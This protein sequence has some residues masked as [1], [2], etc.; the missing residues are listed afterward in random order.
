[1]SIFREGFKPE[2]AAQLK[3]RESAM[4]NR[5]TENIQYI[6]SRNAWVRMASSVNVNGTSDLAKAYVLQGGT[7]NN[8][9]LKNWTFK[10]GIGET[11]KEAYSTKTPYGTDH[12]LGIRPMPG[13]TGIDVKSKSAYGSLREVTV[14]FQCW[15]IRQLEELEL[16]YMRPGYTALVEWGW[17]PYLDN[18]KGYTATFNDFY[19][20]TLL[21]TT[22]PTNRSSIF[23]DLYKQSVSQSGNYD[24]MFGYVKNYNWSARPDGGYDCQT[25]IISTGEI[26]ESLKV[27]YVLPNLKDYGIYDTNGKGF[28]N[29]IITDG[30]ITTDK[31]RPAYEKNTLA[32]IWTELYWKWSSSSGA[33]VSGQKAILDIVRLPFPGTINA[34][35]SMIAPGSQ[36][37]VYIDLESVFNILNEYIIAK[38]SKEELI[39]L[40]TRTNTY[41]SNGNELTCVAHPLQISTDPLVC[42]IK[43]TTWEN[44]ILKTVVS[45]TQAAAAAATATATTIAEDIIKGFIDIYTDGQTAVDA[46]GRI[47]SPAEYKAVD[48]YFKN[49]TNP[50]YKYTNGGLQQAF[51]DNWITKAPSL[52]NLNQTIGNTTYVVE[53]EIT[54]IYYLYKIN[55]AFKNGSSGTTATFQIVDTSNSTLEIGAFLTGKTTPNSVIDMAKL[56]DPAPQTTTVSSAPGSGRAGGSQAQITSYTNRYSAVYKPQ[57]FALAASTQAQTSAT[58]TLNS[59]DAIDCMAQINKSLKYDYF[60]YTPAGAAK[61]VVDYTKEIGTIGN[62]YICLDFLYKLSISSQMESQDSKEKQEINLYSY[63]KNIASGMNAALGSVSNF[64]VHVDPVDN[65]GRI[66]DVNYCEPDKKAHLL[67]EFNIQT[68]DSVIRNFKLE[69][70]IFPNQSAIIAIGAQASGGQLG[71]QNNTMVDYNTTLTDRVLGDKTFPKKSNALSKYKNNTSPGMA[72]G[73]ASIVFL[74]ATM[75]TQPAAGAQSQFKEASS[76]ARSGLR[77]LIVYFQNITTSPSANRNIIPT[78]LSFEMD[79]IGGL[80]IGQLFK[81]DQSVLPRGYKGLKGKGS[82]IAQTI[83]GISHKID[84]GDWTT[85]I[86]SLMV[87]LDNVKSGFGSLNIA[88][89]V[90]AA[91]QTVISQGASSSPAGGGGGG[92]STYTGGTDSKAGTVHEMISPQQGKLGYSNTTNKPTKLILHYTDGYNNGDSTFST[93][94]SNG[95]GIHYAIDRGGGY[96]TG[97]PYNQTVVHANHFNPNSIGIE[98][99]NRGGFL[100]VGGIGLAVGGKMQDGSGVIWEN[101]A[102]E[103]TSIGP[104]YFIGVAFKNV[105]TPKGWWGG[106]IDLGFTYGGYRYYEEYTDIQLAALENRIRDILAKCPLI[107]PSY[108]TVGAFKLLGKEENIYREVFGM[109]IPVSPPTATVGNTPTPGKVYDPITKYGG[110]TKTTAGTSPT[111][112]G[113]FAHARAGGTAKTPADHYDIAPTPKMV[114]MLARL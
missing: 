27:N 53:P 77:D 50:A 108:K 82:E 36:N 69:S 12:K 46:V 49:G 48:E 70:K 109:N 33:L 56:I 30:G 93:I 45:N 4:L 13:I 72:A 90:A 35:D 106:I 47:T 64:E 107:I 3:K 5:T 9:A 38:D 39:K 73:L 66:I 28:L 26:I 71:I 42:L 83:T 17:V 10:T 21:S 81:I 84:N 92:G 65:I 58:L 96:W 94:I 74:L 34:D 57:S 88:S 59:Q 8:G 89:I 86:D 80:V 2:I 1:M 99:C 112:V 18:T 19:S 54:A 91:V 67:H 114:A 85:S 51:T 63:I 68:L 78:K 111:A 29:D 101:K 43:N 25:M 60:S 40:S 32:G 11:G 16:L 44:N 102:G 98:I 37:R 95:F 62:I 24:A 52:N 103:W 100:D 23:L 61:Q 15:D 110:A 97:N 22:S 41:S 104:K 20:D 7:L 76:R 87:I 79:G 55:E 105:V 31:Y 6:N 113:I 75:K 14:N